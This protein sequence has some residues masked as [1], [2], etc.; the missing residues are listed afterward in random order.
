MYVYKKENG[1][2]VVGFYE[3]NPP[4]TWILDSSYTNSADAARRVHWLNGGDAR[5]GWLENL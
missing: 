4:Y 3:P 2:W 5:H 1:N